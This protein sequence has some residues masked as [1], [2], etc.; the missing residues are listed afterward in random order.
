MKNNIYV[1]R[2]K[3]FS[4]LKNVAERI[5][6]ERR[7]LQGQ[8]ISWESFT[9][10]YFWF[11][12]PEEDDDYMNECWI[13]KRTTLKDAVNKY[14]ID[15]RY[16]CNLEVYGRDQGIIVN[17]G[18]A[19]VTKTTIKDFKKITNVHKS[20]IKSYSDLLGI[21]LNLDPILKSHIRRLRDLGIFTLGQLEYDRKIKPAL[22]NELKAI[23]LKSLPPANTEE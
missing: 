14:F 2:Q 10:D 3:D 21:D 13:R 17:I 11:D 22:K 20:G 15:Q 1:I 6:A 12:L 5:Y 19:L 23:I 4:H 16:L 8:L 9:S 7:E 18:E